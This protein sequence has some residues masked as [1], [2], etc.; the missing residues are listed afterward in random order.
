MRKLFPCNLQLLCLSVLLVALA[1]QSW[2]SAFLTR[3]YLIG[4]ETISYTDEPGISAGISLANFASDARAP[5]YSL[6]LFVATLGEIPNPNAITYAHCGDTVFGANQSCE[7]AAADGGDQ[8]VLR[9]DP[10]I[11]YYTKHT[12]ELFGRSILI[13]KLLALAS[14]VFLFVAVS[15]WINPVWSLLAVGFVWIQITPGPIRT[16]LMSFNPKVSFRL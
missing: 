11:Y 1:V 5:G 2:S 10:V 4:H 14:V 6:F 13:G 12:A 3:Q 15:A 9:V 7:K 16:L 8:V